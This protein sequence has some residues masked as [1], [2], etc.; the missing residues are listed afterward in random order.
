MTDRELLEFVFDHLKTARGDGQDIDMS[1]LLAAINSKTATNIE[2]LALKLAIWRWTRMNDAQEFDP[3]LS[4]EERGVYSAFRDAL[5]LAWRPDLA[6]P[7]DYATD[8][9]AEQMS[10]AG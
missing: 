8:F 6:T 1:H 3:P 9:Y 5:M 2:E 4:L 10:S 7:T